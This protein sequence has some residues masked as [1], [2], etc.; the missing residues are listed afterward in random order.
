MVPC[1]FF[2]LKS[3]RL[4]MLTVLKLH[5]CEGI[6]SA[7]MVAIAHSYML[8]V[9]ILCQI[10]V[11][12]LLSLNALNTI[13][14]EIMTFCRFWSLTI[15]TYLPLLSWIFH[16]CRISVL[17][18]VASKLLLSFHPALPPCEKR[19]ISLFISCLIEPLKLCLS[20]RFADLNLRTLMLSSIMVS[21]CSVLHRISITSNSL[22]VCLLLKHSDSSFKALLIYQ[23]YESWMVFW[24]CR[25]Y[26]CRSKRA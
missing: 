17:Y 8:E 16:A 12:L 23:S 22:Q 26:H 5:S 1:L 11:M 10:L 20:Y 7:S 24:T 3:V 6:T 4:P 19:Y 15:A 2:S 25:N 21:N 9:C 14:S 18:I 13:W